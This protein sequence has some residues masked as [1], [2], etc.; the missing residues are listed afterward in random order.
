MT[1][2]RT[3]GVVA[4]VCSIG[5]VVNIAQAQPPRPVAVDSTNQRLRISPKPAKSMSMKTTNS[6]LTTKVGQSA[7]T[8]PKVPAVSSTVSQKTVDVSTP[9]PP[10]WR[11]RPKV[12]NTRP[13]T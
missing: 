8:I 12:A 1:V 11:H 6:G 7:L 5:F 10:T 2:M 3:S 13:P 4:L 9:P